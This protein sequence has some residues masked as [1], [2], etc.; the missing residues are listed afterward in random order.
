MKKEEI[1]IINEECIKRL[2]CINYNE[3]ICELLIKKGSKL[4]KCNFFVS[5]NK[6][7]KD[8]LG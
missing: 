2:D 5:K 8:Y 7:K 4:V 6:S 1:K 3:S